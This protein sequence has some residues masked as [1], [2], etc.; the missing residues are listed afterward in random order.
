VEPEGLLIDGARRAAVAVRELWW[1]NRPLPPAAGLPLARVK[2]RLE[3]VAGALYGETPVILPSDP[4]PR[5]TW[6]TRAFGRAP[7]HLTPRT[8]QASTD[9]ASVWLPRAVQIDDDDENAAIATY[10]LLTLE[11]V[12]RAARGTPAAAPSDRLEHDL[13]ALAEAA[14]VDWQLARDFG[15]IAADLRVARAAALRA[16]PALGRLTAFERRVE[17][18]VQAVL[19]ADPIKPP[20]RIPLTA[21]PAESLRWARATARRLRGTAGGYRGMSIVPLWGRLVAVPP[22]ASDRPAATSEPSTAGAMRSASLARRPRMRPTAEGEDDDRPGTW[23]VRPDEP[24]ESVEDP[25][26]L[27]RPAD[28]EDNAKAADLAD[29]LSELPEAR[30]VRTPGRPREVLDSDAGWL[31]GRP[32]PAGRESAGDGVVY[33]EWDFRLGAYRQRGAVVW[34]RVAPAGSGAWVE[35]VMTRHAA[36]VRRVRHRFDGLRPRR[37]RVS[38]QDDGPDLDLSAYVA[39]FADWRADQ[40]GDDRLYAAA[41]P[42]RRDLA[43]MLL[44]DISASTDSW[45]SGGLRIIDVEKESLIVLLEALDALGDRH[46]AVAFSSEGAGGVRA[47]TVKDFAEPVSVEI[48]RRVAALEPDGY[49]RTGAALRHASTLLARQPARHRL[50]LVLTDGKPNDVDHYPGRYGVQDTRQ[51][52]AEARMQGLVPF[53]LTVDREA[54][55]YMSSIFGPRGYALLRRQELLPAVLV[56]VVRRLLVT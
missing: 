34:P 40:P 48:R 35:D 1:R 3:L 36:L 19:S 21:T 43:L 31:G 33:P 37:V 44:V 49:T 6:L 54:P 13:Y 39:A 12:A 9:G 32:A 47:L 11:Q 10:R 18:L 4:P 7:R 23:M 42:A 17:R 52:V 53:C 45:V 38:R 22:A 29:S 25:M 15:G 20:P 14:A 41:R 26:G 30:V 50:L 27:Q 2:R 24:M 8:A 46:G 56:E 5:P 51:A 28:Q 16:R 55:A